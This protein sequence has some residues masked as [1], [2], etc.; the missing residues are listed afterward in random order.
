MC[1]TNEIDD[2]ND[3]LKRN[4]QELI[5]EYFLLLLRRPFLGSLAHT[6]TGCVGASVVGGGVIF[7]T[8]LYFEAFF[9][10]GPLGAAKGLLSATR[11][12]V[13]ESGVVADAGRHIYAKALEIIQ[14]E[15]EPAQNIKEAIQNIRET[16]P[17]AETLITGEGFLGY[18]AQTFLGLFLP[19]IGQVFDQIEEAITWSDEHKEELE[20]SEIIA[21]AATGFIDAHIR[22]KEQLVSTVGTTLYGTI[23]GMGLVLSL[24]T[25]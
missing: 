18:L 5:R 7:H 23:A 3:P 16:Y 6:A 4:N 15:D 1:T 2:K 14:N 22:A 9:I 25:G 21:R 8:T 17:L 13:L 24:V 11:E 20:D 19:S 10:L 12:I